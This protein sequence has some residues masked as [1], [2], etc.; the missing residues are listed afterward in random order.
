MPHHSVVRK[1]SV[2]SALEAIGH[3]LS[4]RSV[5]AGS[6]FENDAAITT[7]AAPTGRPVHGSRLGKDD[8]ADGAASILSAFE[9]VEHTVL[10]CAVGLGSELIY[11]AKIICSIVVCCAIEIALAV[12][13]QSAVGKSSVGLALERV[14]RG[15]LPASCGVGKPEGNAFCIC[16]ACGG[17]AVEAPLIRK[18]AA[19]RAA[20]AIGPAGEGM[21]HL[22]VPGAVLHRSQQEN[23]AW[24]LK[25]IHAFTGGN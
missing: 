4:P 2:G 21:D 12:R 5:N 8:I 10:P 16:A 25:V 23:G 1:P 24:N 15:E 3:V 6:Q 14:K 7:R 13:S 17:H 9:A 19:C 11:R 20:C 18:Q 22:Q